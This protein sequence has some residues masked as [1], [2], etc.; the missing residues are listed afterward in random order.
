MKNGWKIKKNV[1]NVTKIENVKRFLHLWLKV[2]AVGV[3]AG[4]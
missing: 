1:K 2:G 3:G 4:E